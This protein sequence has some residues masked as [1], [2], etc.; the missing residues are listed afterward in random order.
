MSQNS[1]CVGLCVL[2]KYAVAD[3]NEPSEEAFNDFMKHLGFLV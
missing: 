3:P 1:D 2:L